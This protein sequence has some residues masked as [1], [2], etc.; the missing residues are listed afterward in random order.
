M[1]KNIRNI[2]YMLSYAFQN[3]RQGRYKTCETEDFDNAKELFAE[4]LIKGISQEVKRGL[5]KG[6]ILKQS[7]LTNPKGKFNITESIKNS[8]IQKRQLVCEYDE[9]SLNSYL[10][11]I[12]KTTVLLLIKSD[13][14]LG[15]KKSLKR[16]MI[17]FNEVEELNPFT[18]NWKIQFNKTNQTYK[19]LIH[20]C[21]LVIKGL[22]QLNNNGQFKIND[23]ID[24]QEMHR[25]YE[26]FIL[27][28]YKK[29]CPNFK[30]SSSQI[31][32]A[33]DDNN[34]IMLPRMQ[35][36][37]MI[38]TKEKVL[39]I[40]AKYYE[41]PTQKRFDTETLHS[42]NLY[43]IFTY[44]KNKSICEKEKQ[45]SGMLLYAKIDE[46]VYLNNSYLM[47]G[48]KISVMTLDLN[49]D[50]KEIKQQLFKIVQDSFG[51]IYS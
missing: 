4:I 8:A 9:F 44:V 46:T 3:L 13:I 21:W 39:I 19:M 31:K 15:R 38:E 18:I 14:S 32:W 37:I 47:G 7:Q 29:E 27:E 16:L 10:N 51:I 24:E 6:C 40:D 26:K 36:D 20:I 17:Y 43:Q 23:I 22:I 12:I 42:N 48:N 5:G 35:S 25:L 11:R 2:Y 50:F 1:I 45:V 41:R 28:F 30:V 34:D 33:L 49:C